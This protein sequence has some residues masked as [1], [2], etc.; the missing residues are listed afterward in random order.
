MWLTEE[1]KRDCW[2]S[3]CLILPGTS[4]KVG[5]I[6]GHLKCLSALPWVPEAFHARLPVSSLQSY[7]R[8]KRVFSLGRLCRSCERQQSSQFFL[9]RRSCLWPNNARKTSGTQGT[10]IFARKLI[11]CKP[12]VFICKTLKKC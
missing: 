9:F 2:Q 10:G 5:K 8:E 4:F 3:E 12:L 1:K 11:L 7:P 6:L